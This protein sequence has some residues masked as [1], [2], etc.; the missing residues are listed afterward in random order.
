[1]G[2]QQLLLIMLGVIIVGIAI[3]VAMGLFGSHNTEANKD[4]ITTS[5]ANIGVDAHAFKLRPKI[6]GGGRPS[7]KNYILPSRFR[8][9]E[10]GTYEVVDATKDNECTI[11]G[12][13]KMN[14]TWIATCKIDENGYTIMSYTGW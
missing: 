3:A 7:F 6:M 14:N 8:E 10:Y 11:R 1:M 4:G 12:I 13:S 2:Q 9:D 5:L